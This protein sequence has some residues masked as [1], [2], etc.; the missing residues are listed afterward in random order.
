VLLAC[1]VELEPD[2]EPF[3][4]GEALMFRQEPIQLV[5]LLR[6]E[7][8]GGLREVGPAHDPGHAIRP[9]TPVGMGRRTRGPPPLPVMRDVVDSVD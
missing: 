3:V 7:A 4:P 1:S 5:H 2:G 8:V 9:V 6:A